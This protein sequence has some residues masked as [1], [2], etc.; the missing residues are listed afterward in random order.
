[1]IN[2]STERLHQQIT[3]STAN[4]YYTYSAHWI[5]VHRL[6]RRYTALKVIQIILTAISTGGFLASMI[7]GNASLSWIGGATSALALG[8]NLYALNFNLPENIKNHTDAANELW[9][10]REAYKSLVNDF[11]DLKPEEVRAKRDALN[12]RIS[13][14]NKQYPGTDDKSFKKAKKDIDKYSFEKGESE[15]IWTYL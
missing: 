6:Q 11:A 2:Y 3:D 12:E 7:A 1:M 15:K 14:I 9:D 10:V 5:I 8:L 13:Q 4:V